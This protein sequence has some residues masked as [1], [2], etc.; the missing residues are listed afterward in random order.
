MTPKIKM[1]NGY[2]LIKDRVS[3]ETKTESGIIIPNDKYQRIA[4]IVAV[5]A[6]SK[7]KVG[8]VIVKPIGKTTPVKIDDVEYECIKESLIFAKM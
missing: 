3:K 8:D 2:V 4:E 1:L 6:I 7:F 5:P